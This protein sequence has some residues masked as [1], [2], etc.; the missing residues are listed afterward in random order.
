M[1]R[2]PP[3]MANQPRVAVITGSTS[4]IGLAIAKRLLHAGYRV[5]LNYANNDERASQAL[6]EC[7]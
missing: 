4:G 7:K 3:E 5:T 6:A 2:A 1:K